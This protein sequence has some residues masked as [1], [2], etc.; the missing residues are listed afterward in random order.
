MLRSEHRAAPSHDDIDFQPHELGRDFREPFAPPFGPAVFD[1]DGAAVDPA[2]FTKPLV[3]SSDKMA[4][5]GRRADAEKPN[6][7]K[8]LLRAGCERHTR[9]RAAKSRDEFAPLHADV[10]KRLVARHL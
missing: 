4:P 3:K 5:G 9:R 10:P 2:E 8:L 7:G 6:G 1:R